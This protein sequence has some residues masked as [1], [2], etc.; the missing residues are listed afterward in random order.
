[1]E[2]TPILGLRKPV[3]LEDL[4]SPIEYIVEN[5]FPVYT[6]EGYY[7]I[8]SLGHV[9]KFGTQEYV[10][11]YKTSKYDIVVLNHPDN[12]YVAATFNLIDVYSA[13][14]LGDTQYMQQYS[15]RKGKTEQDE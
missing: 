14:V 15:Y 11:V 9:R 7:E 2:R 1:M 13:S 5:W 4:R 8:S 3:K 10:Y 12:Y 6:F